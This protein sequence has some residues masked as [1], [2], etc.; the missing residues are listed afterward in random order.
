M[1]TFR[2]RLPPLDMNFRRLLGYTSAI[3]VHISKQKW[4]DQLGKARCCHCPPFLLMLASWLKATWAW[5]GQQEGIRLPAK[6]EGCRGIWGGS[7]LWGFFT[8][9]VFKSYLTKCLKNFVKEGRN[10]GLPFPTECS[11]P[12]TLWALISFFFFLAHNIN[13]IVEQPEC[14]LRGRERPATFC[15]LHILLIFSDQKN[16]PG[17]PVTA[18]CM[19]VTLNPARSSCLMKSSSG[20]AGENYLKAAILAI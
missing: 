12:A 20:T 19:R 2:Y 7:G 8:H 13:F 6:A 10:P 18:S 9:P 3:L 5:W 17:Y 11:L 4:L 1:I 16:H 14:F 15:S